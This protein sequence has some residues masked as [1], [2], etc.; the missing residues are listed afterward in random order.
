[1]TPQKAEKFPEVL[2]QQQPDKPNIE[3]IETPLVQSKDETQSTEQQPSEPPRTIETSIDVPQVEKP[4]DLHRETSEAVSVLL[5]LGLEKNIFPV[6]FTSPSKKDLR[7]KGSTSSNDSM[8]EFKS[9]IPFTSDISK[10]ETS[11]D[12]I[13]KA[14]PVVKSDSELKV[15]VIEAPAVESKPEKALSKTPNFTSPTLSVLESQQNDLVFNPSKMDLNA[16]MSLTLSLNNLNNSGSF[17]QI[18]DDSTQQ[19]H[20]S[21]QN[22]FSDINFS[23][24]SSNKAADSDNLMNLIATA[25]TEQSQQSVVAKEPTHTIEPKPEKE[26]A[27]VQ[28]NEPEKITVTAQ[29]YV[30]EKQQIQTEQ[31]QQESE[32][33]SAPVESLPEHQ[34]Q[35]QQQFNHQ[36]QAQYNPAP[37]E[38]YQQT[39]YNQ[40]QAETAPS[41]QQFNQSMI[42]PTKQQQSQ[43]NPVPIKTDSQALQQPQS[44]FNPPPVENSLP[45]YQQQTVAHHQHSQLSQAPNE[46]NLQQQSNQNSAAESSFTKVSNNGQFNQTGH[47]AEGQEYNARSKNLGK[48]ISLLLFYSWA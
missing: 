10:I 46:S 37:V 22:E 4:V 5:D 18:L 44:Q 24:T 3:P 28:N 38:E 33:S 25:V 2:P 36:Q 20:T 13:Q 43:F 35:Q 11:L 41:R 6:S 30:P 7:S 12:L 34:L 39:G 23:E 8:S 42:E 16:A 48:I 32:Y 9:I 17:N 14:E 27:P 21:K 19:T 45:K 40:A 15:Q 29:T 47:V 31:Q 26:Q 1:M